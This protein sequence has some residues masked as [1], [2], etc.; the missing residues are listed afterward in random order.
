MKGEIILD[1]GVIVN[2][3]ALYVKEGEWFAVIGGNNGY[4]YFY[5]RRC[6]LESIIQDPFFIRMKVYN[7]YRIKKLNIHDSFMV[8]ISTEGDISIYDIEELLLF[9]KIDKTMTIDNYASLTDYKINCRLHL[10]DTLYM[11]SENNACK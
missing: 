5:P 10:L 7:G 8:T 9:G 1:E 2:D 3:V 6:F 11:K 4:A